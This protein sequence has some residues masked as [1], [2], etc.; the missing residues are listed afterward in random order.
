M[1]EN[2]LETRPNSGAPSPEQNEQ[3]SPAPT[4]RK[5]ISPAKL[6]ANRRNGQNSKGAKT[7]AGKSRSRWNALKHGVLARRLLV[8]KDDDSQTYT[9]LLENLRHDL[10]PGNA[11][12]EILV[13]KIAIAYWRL[14][15]AYGYEAEFARTR[16]EFLVVAD[17]MGRYANT[18]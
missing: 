14:H 4:L 11:L 18:I 9:L 7:E 16:G 5:A 12:E 1:N 13:E 10:N 2:Q 15:I 3:T 6:A 17:R 8:L